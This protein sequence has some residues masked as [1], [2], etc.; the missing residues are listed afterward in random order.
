MPP[1]TNNQM[2]ESIV[3]NFTPEQK[4]FLAR[5]HQEKEKEKQY[6]YKPM[7]TLSNY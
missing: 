4:E 5:Y 6:C 3:I 1:L 2:K 7:R